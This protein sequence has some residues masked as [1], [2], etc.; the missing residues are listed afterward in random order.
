MARALR[1]TARTVPKEIEAPIAIDDQIGED[2]LR[3]AG[4]IDADLMVFATALAGG[5]GPCGAEFDVACV[6][7]E[8]RRALGL[9]FDRLEGRLGVEGQGLDCA[10]EEAVLGQREVADRR[11]VNSPSVLSFRLASI[12][13]LMAI[14]RPVA[15][16]PAPGRGPRC[17]SRN[18]VGHWAET[19]WRTGKTEKFVSRCKGRLACRRKFLRMARCLVEARMPCIRP[20]V[21]SAHHGHE[22]DC[23]ST[24]RKVVKPFGARGSPPLPRN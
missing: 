2:G 3:E 11:N 5:L 15:K 9:A 13:F 8:G 6:E 21:R 16:R 23:A 10:L 20:P 19:Q 12:A 18:G 24:S 22:R 4:I 17:S 7:A 14:E 1:G